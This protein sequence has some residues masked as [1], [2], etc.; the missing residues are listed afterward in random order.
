MVQ[1][2]GGE[3]ERGEGWKAEVEGVKSREKIRV[4]T[5][6]GKHMGA[7][8]LDG[9]EEVGWWNANAME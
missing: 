6:T 4:Y 1:C 5:V 7:T 9:R 8:N 3:S 2:C